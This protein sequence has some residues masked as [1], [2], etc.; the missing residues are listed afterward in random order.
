MFTEGWAEYCEETLYHMGLFGKENP[1]RL[2]ALLERDR[3]Q[4]ALMVADIKLHNDL[5]TFAELIDWLAKT[6]KTETESGRFF[7]RRELMNIAWQPTS[8]LNGPLGKQLLLQM[9]RT[10]R[11]NGGIEFSLKEFHDRLLL[12]GTISPA[13][14]KGLPGLAAE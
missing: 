5:A 12:E 9:L 13:L 10:G 4:I 1:T 2:L 8:A 6:L 7:L 14:L 3:L 11:D